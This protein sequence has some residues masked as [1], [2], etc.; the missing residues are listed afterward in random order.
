[1]V[2][3]PCFTISNDL[4][5]MTPKA[6]ASIFWQPNGLLVVGWDNFHFSWLPEGHALDREGSWAPGPSSWVWV[7]LPPAEALTP[8]WGTLPTSVCPR[9]RNQNMMTTSKH[10]CTLCRGTGCS[11]DNYFEIDCVGGSFNQIVWQLFIEGKVWM[12]QQHWEGFWL[13]N[14]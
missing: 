8:R 1:M 11:E 4:A 2:N 9:K 5:A 13:S 12:A 7:P 6:I 14:I 10:K 3:L